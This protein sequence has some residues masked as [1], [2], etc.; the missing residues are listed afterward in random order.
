MDFYN[1]YVME[2]YPDVKVYFVDIEDWEENDRYT[3][4]QNSP[5][6]S[7]TYAIEHLDYVNKKTSLIQK[8]TWYLS[9]YVLLY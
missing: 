7:I 2:N 8:N 5:L 1:S 4:L 9:E 3:M 6:A